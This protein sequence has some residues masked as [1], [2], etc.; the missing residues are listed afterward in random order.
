L[1][2]FLP[3]VLFDIFC[4]HVLFDGEEL[5]QRPAF[6]PALFPEVGRPLFDRP[7]FG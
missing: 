4:S 2:Y 7:G 6:D 1:E 3:Q 5:C